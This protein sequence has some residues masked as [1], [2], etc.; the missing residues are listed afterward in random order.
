METGYE[1]N[2]RASDVLGLISLGW[3][4]IFLFVISLK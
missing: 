2:E 3:I 4:V 1:N